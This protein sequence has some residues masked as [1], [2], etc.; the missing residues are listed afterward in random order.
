MRVG[1]CRIRCGRSCS[2][3]TTWPTGGPTTTSTSLAAEPDRR[4]DRRLPRHRRR[5]QPIRRGACVPRATG[6]AAMTR[7]RAAATCAPCSQPRWRGVF[8]HLRG[9]KTPDLSDARSRHRMLA[10]LAALVAVL[11]LTG[12][13]VY[14]LITGPPPAPS[15]AAMT[16]P[17]RSQL[18]PCPPSRC[19]PRPPPARGAALRGP[20]DVRRQRRHGAVRAWDTAS[21][22]MPLDYTSVILAVGDPRCGAGRARRRH[23]HL[24][25]LPRSLGRTAPVRHHPTPDHRHHLRPQ[26]LG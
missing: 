16:A 9:M 14:G 4:A 15:P 8:V 19:P 22:F 5:H 18:S 13:G 25:P 10:V 3:G 7:P 2:P 17:R 20:R 11:V 23:R 12:I 24:P 1:R 6:C 21:G 26:R